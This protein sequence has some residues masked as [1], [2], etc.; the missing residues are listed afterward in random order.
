MQTPSI[1]LGQDTQGFTPNALRRDG[2]TVI[3]STSERYAPVVARW[4]ESRKTTEQ[5]TMGLA[6]PN[7][8][9]VG[10]QFR[11]TL[12]IAPRSAS[13]TRGACLD[14]LGL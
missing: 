4:L 10:Q 7:E 9:R 1:R 2:A 6:S 13:R 8:P 3:A 14:G 12:S 11:A 5:K